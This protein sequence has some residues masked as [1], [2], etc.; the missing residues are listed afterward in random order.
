[1]SNS[2][3][4]DVYRHV[5]FAAWVVVE[6]LAAVFRAQAQ[7]RIRRDEIIRDVTSSAPDAI[8]ATRRSPRTPCTINVVIASLG[9]PSFSRVSIFLCGAI[10]SRAS[11]VASV[12]FRVPSRFTS[13]L[14]LF[15]G[16]HTLAADHA[17][18]NPLNRMTRRFEWI[19]KIVVVTLL[20]SH[21][22][23]FVL[24]FVFFFYS[25][26]HLMLFYT[27]YK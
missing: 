1:M 15:R 11:L 5:G 21:S 26:F 8:S 17:R 9:W 27:R 13:A 7:T 19:R 2:C 14:T 3:S 18:E 25:F 10:D 20:H 16:L 4:N 22:H 12:D 6:R 23:R 24:K